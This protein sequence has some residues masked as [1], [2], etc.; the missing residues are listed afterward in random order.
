MLGNIV[1]MSYYYAKGD[2][3]VGPKS[4]KEL[5]ELCRAGEITEDTQVCM[6]EGESWQSLSTLLPFENSSPGETA[7][8][9]AIQPPPMPQVSPPTELP[10]PLRSSEYSVVPFVAVIAHREGSSAAAAQLQELIQRQA[11]N[12][13]EYVRLESVE[14]YIAGDS[15][16]F[17]LGATPLRTTVYSMVVF[18]R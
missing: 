2:E 12:G 15:G 3:A 5:V 8:P 13:W 6:E 17:G 10:P 16:C 18:K 14:T 7:S 4:L 11:R 1:R 9:A